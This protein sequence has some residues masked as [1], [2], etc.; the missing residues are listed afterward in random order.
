MNN[1][2]SGR[3]KVGGFL[4]PK[5]MDFI[6]AI[7]KRDPSGYDTVAVRENKKSYTYDQ[8]V[9]SAWNTSDL[10]RDSGLNVVSFCLNA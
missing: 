7:L 2:V 6:K 1:S 4:F 8:I 9:T 5:Y 10:L 3:E